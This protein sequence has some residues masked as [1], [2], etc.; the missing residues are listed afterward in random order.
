MHLNRL[1]CLVMCISVPLLFSVARAG[2]EDKVV[3]G[4]HDIVLTDQ[5]NGD[6]QW[7]TEKTG[8]FIPLD[9]PFVDEE[10]KKIKLGEFIDRPTL[11]LPIYFYCPNS[12]SRNHAN[13]AEALNR[14]NFKPGKDYRVVAV[15]FNEIETVD[16]ARRAKNN[17]L[18]LV[19]AEFPQHEWKFLT[20]SSAAI[21]SVTDA[22]GFRFQKLDDHT[23]IHPSALMAID[24][25]GRI[26]RYV[27]GSFVPGDI[28]MALTAAM[29][30]TPVLSVKRLLDFC[31]NYDPNANKSV[32]QIVKVSVLIF[33]AIVVALSVFYFGKKRRKRQEG[34]YA[35]EGNSQDDTR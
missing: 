1:V 10:G 14:V 15:S 29:E 34:H 21:T 31:F 33:F 23:F 13:L 20:G 26:I 28:D 11:L 17:Y 5:R 18:Q 9:A 16:N 8:S 25:E 19:S 3:H 27:Y 6:K 35:N 7:V 30:G 22:L 4:S 24:G 2:V 12:C 32:F